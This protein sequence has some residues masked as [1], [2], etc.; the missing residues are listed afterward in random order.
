MTIGEYP[1]V[2]LIVARERARRYAE[3]V[4]SGV[5]PVA[6]ARKDRGA[7]KNVDTVREFGEYW[8]EQHRTAVAGKSVEYRRPLKWRFICGC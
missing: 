4:A 6:D 1:A 8:I 5:S 2:A 3:I 7:M